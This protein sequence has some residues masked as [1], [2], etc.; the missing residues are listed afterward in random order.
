[1]SISSEMMDLSKTNKKNKTTYLYRGQEDKSAPKGR[2]PVKK[3][4]K[5]TP[6]DHIST[7]L[8]SYPAGSAT[9]QTSV[10]F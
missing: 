5:I 1:M 2:E 9:N 10:N 7:F 3:V 4:Y 6:T 8:P